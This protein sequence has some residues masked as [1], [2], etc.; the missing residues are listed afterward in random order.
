MKNIYEIL[1]EIGVEVP[2]EKKSDFDKSFGGNYKT[3]VDY[4]K[5]KEKLD[6]ANQSIKELN[7]TIKG[8]EGTD[9]TIKTL[10]GKVEAYEQAEA[11]RVQAEKDR[12]ADEEMN[13]RITETIGEVEFINEFTKNSIYQAIKDGVKA[14]ST[15][16]V[17]SIFEEL[18]KD[19]EGIFK[20]PQ[21][22]INLPKGDGGGKPNSA[23]EEYLAK[24]YKDNPFYQGGK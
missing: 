2:E 19:K 8:Y 11:D 13:A 17:K 22:P 16:G 4:Q 6:T 18:T 20:N 24:K 7:E 23:D 14:D 1:T 15:K 10:Q 21:D 5:Q 3:I 12:K 9:E